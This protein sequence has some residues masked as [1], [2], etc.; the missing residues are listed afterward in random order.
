MVLLDC[1]ALDNIETVH[2][3]QYPKMNP[4]ELEVAQIDT[5]SHHLRVDSGERYRADYYRHMYHFL[6]LQGC[7][8]DILQLIV[9]VALGEYGG[10]AWDPLAQ[11]SGRDDQLRH[12][13]EQ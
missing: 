9:R 2:R 3:C 11:K 1:V 7:C 4:G 8:V 13:L 6:G 12:P 10:E 5:E